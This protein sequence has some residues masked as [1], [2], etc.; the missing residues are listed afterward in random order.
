MLPWSVDSG[1]GTV[2]TQYEKV[3]SFGVAGATI[4]KPLSAGDDPLTTPCA[5][6]QFDNAR[7]AL[8]NGSV[9]V[10]EQ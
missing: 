8:C 2:E 7:L 1:V 10:V 5:W 4:Y 3:M 6:I 9:C